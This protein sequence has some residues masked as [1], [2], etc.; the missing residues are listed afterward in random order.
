MGCCFHCS[1]C[2][3]L[4]WVM[5]NPTQYFRLSKFLLLLGKHEVISTCLGTPYARD[6]G[7]Y[8]I[9]YGSFFYSRLKLHRLKHCVHLQWHCSKLKY[10]T[11]KLVVK[12]FQICKKNFDFSSY[13]S[14]NI[15]AHTA[16]KI[17]TFNPFSLYGRKSLTPFISTRRTEARLGYIIFSLC[18]S[19]LA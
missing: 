13:F 14:L 18:S 12:R 1:L 8:S 7:S 16:L 3:S 4:H 17:Y 9:E 5:C 10:F 15:Y 6:K 2:C 19:V 11:K